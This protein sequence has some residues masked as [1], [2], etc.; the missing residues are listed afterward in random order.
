MVFGP[1]TRAFFVS[2]GTGARIWAS[3]GPEGGPFGHAAVI[4][5]GGVPAWPQFELHVAQSAAQVLF[6]AVDEIRW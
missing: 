4:G 3:G 2:V 6:A 5:T 1:Q